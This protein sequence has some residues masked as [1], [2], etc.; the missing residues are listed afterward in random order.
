MSN[1]LQ[2]PDFRR[3]LAAG[4][5]SSATSQMTATAAGWE[6]YART[7]QPWALGLLGFLIAFPFIVFAL[8]AGTLADRRPRKTILLVGAL[9]SALALAALA[10]VTHFQASIALFFVLIFGLALCSAWSGP[11]RQAFVTNLVPGAQI[12][13]ATKWTSLRWNVASLVGPM[14]GGLLIAYAGGAK[15]VFALDALAVVLFCALIWPIQAHIPPKPTQRATWRDTIAGWHFIRNQP[16]LLSSISLDM[17]AVLFGGATAL[18][19]I[20]AS[21]ILNVGAEG[22]GPLRAAPAAGALLTSLFLTRRGPFQNAGPTLLWCVAGF[23]AATIL[24]GL[25]HNFLLSLAALALLGGFDQVSVVVRHTLL[26]LVTPDAMR[27]RVNAVNSVFI[28]TSNE[29]GELES[30]LVAQWLGPIITVAGGGAVTI[31]VVAT[32]ALM[33]PRLRHLRVLEELTPVEDQAQPVKASDPSFSE[34]AH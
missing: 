17:V 7:G 10:V 3:Y 6:V 31:G 21:D 2:I 14:L 15:T 19:P 32:I 5:L 9:C 16:L 29:I 20:Y 27:G 18:L 28:S 4:T 8:P 33:A 22:L 1:V 13:D 23:G 34:I 30:G 25:S 24:F 11:A 12:A 26:Q